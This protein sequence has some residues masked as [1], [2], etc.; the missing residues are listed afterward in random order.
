MSNILDKINDSHYTILLPIKLDG[1]DIFSPDLAS[2]THEEDPL[3]EKQRKRK[4]PNLSSM[5]KESAISIFHS[6]IEADFS[7]G[8]KSMLKDLHKQLI[9]SQR[10]NIELVKG[11][12]KQR[13]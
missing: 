2:P 8:E 11:P 9:P 12:K 6:H 3:H 1:G 5:I 13:R 4:I 7:R 10:R